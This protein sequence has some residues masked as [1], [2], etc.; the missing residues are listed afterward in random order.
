MRAGVGMGMPHRRETCREMYGAS[1]DE[2]LNTFP[3][4]TESTSSGLTLAAERAALAAASCKSTQVL[5][6]NLPPKVPKGV[7]FAP[8]IKIPRVKEAILKETGFKRAVDYADRKSLTTNAQ[9]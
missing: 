7:R 5:S 8:T 1:F 9:L 6:A 2:Q 4:I 3:I